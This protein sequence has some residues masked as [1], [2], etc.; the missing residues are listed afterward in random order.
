MNGFVLIVTI[1]YLVGT[2]GSS[3]G[4][5]ANVSTA[6]FADFRSCAEAADTTR[7]Q[8]FASIREYETKP[9]VHAVC[10]PQQRPSR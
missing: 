2:G 8:I 10:L 9:R 1:I 7:R 6:P 5:A 4:T 3:S